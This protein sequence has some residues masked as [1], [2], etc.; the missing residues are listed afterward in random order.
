MKEYEHDGFFCIDDID[1]GKVDSIRKIFQSQLIED[2]RNLLKKKEEAA[3][4]AEPDMEMAICAGILRKYEKWLYEN[5]DTREMDIVLRMLFE[6]SYATVP[7]KKELTEEDRLFL[8]SVT[9]RHLPNK[10][11][12]EEKEFNNKIR[13]RQA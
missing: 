13:E 5:F 7:K 11:R 10:K 12:N 1:W 4:N 6:E 3:V 9:K 8:D 2:V